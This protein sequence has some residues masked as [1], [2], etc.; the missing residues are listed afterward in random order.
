MILPDWKIDDLCEGG[1]LV[2]PYDVERVNPASVDLCLGGEVYDLINNRHVAGDGV[3]RV[4]PGQVLLVTTV[5][6]VRLPA[7]L[8]GQLILK[9]SMGRRGLVMPAAGWVDPG[10]CGQLTIQLSAWVPVT[11]T[12]GQPFVQLVLHELSGV[13]EKVYAGRYQNQ[14]GVTP[15]R[16]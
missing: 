14:V 4:L 10:F 15:A 1:G 5:E 12:A 13:A 16:G 6:T 3:I 2:E 7:G 11:L 9:S 8:A